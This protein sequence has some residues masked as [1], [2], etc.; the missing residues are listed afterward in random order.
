MLNMNKDYT[1]IK[2][3]DFRHKLTQ[4]K[5]SLASGEIYQ[6]T[7]KGVPL[8]YFVPADYELELKRKKLDQVKFIDLLNQI[9]GKIELKDEVKHYKNIKD[10][11]HHLL[12]LKYKKYLK[13]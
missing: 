2:L 1:K 6:V 8:A 10:A 7:E 3:R 11:Y 4:L 9:A 13:K 12:D 5:N